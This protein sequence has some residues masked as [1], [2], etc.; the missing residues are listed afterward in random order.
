MNL[1]NNLLQ[2]S[3]TQTKKDIYNPVKLNVTETVNN[4]IALLGSAIN[5]KKI[6]VKSTLNNEE[7][8]FADKNMIATVFRNLLSNAIKFTPEEGTITIAS[9]EKEGIFQYS[10]SDSGPG[11]SEEDQKK[12]FRIDVKNKDIGND[13]DKKGTGLGLIL[14]HEFI[15]Q[16]NQK[17][18]VTSTPGKGCTFSF[19]LEKFS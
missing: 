5:D 12:L 14:C 1:F 16:H 7:W 9:E 18:W 19:T 17:I 8:V 13:P 6:T 15:K 11:L 4:C 3:V 10:V 2:W